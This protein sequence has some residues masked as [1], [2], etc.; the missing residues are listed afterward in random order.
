V[1][2]NRQEDD[3]Y[4]S[5]LGIG[6]LVSSLNDGGMKK[7][8]STLESTKEKAIQSNLKEKEPF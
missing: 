3:R 5:G 7:S 8:T 1:T 4:V 6:N 2:G